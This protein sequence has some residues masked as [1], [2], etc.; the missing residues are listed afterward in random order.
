M[1]VQLET[2]FYYYYY[3]RKTQRTDQLGNIRHRRIEGSLSIKTTVVSRLLVK[4]LELLRW[5]I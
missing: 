4:S 5:G 3:C 2:I 1:F